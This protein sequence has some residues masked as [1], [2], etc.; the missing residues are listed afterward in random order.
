MYSPLTLD[1]LRVLDAIDRK[2]SFAAA[3]DALFRVPSAISYTVTKLEEE[4]G[5]ALFDRSRR[6]AEL[7]PVGR[8]VLE[9][10]RHILTA[11]EELTRMAKAA[12]D[13]WE[14]ELR[15]AVDSVLAVEPIYD[16]LAEFQR[17]GH[18]TEI[19]LLDEVLGGSWD[20]LSAK[21]C[22]LVIGAVGEP[23]SS[24][25]ACH[26]L[27]EVD[28]VFAAAAAHPLSALPPPVPVQAV[29]AYP[30]VVVADSSRY[31]P[32]RSVGLL[33]G[34]SRLVVPSMDRKIEA[35]RQGLGVGYLPAYRI[36][37]ELADGSLKILALDSPPLRQ[38]IC[39]AWHPANDGKAL[40]WFVERLKRYLFDNEKGLVVAAE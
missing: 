39:T 12:A 31:L 26:V 32:S 40:Q 22:D 21:R 28:F 13:G 1:A 27:G 29:Q 37:H 10:G 36:R 17:A 8:L 38:R 11:V 33:D 20:A 18:R 15:I 34:R 5:V 4:L 19:R 9:Q 24:G 35:Q 25:F 6:K 23:P 2:G 16:L 14:A 3:A 30:T 7:T